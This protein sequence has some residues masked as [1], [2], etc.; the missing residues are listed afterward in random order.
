MTPTLTISIGRIAA[1]IGVPNKAENAA[2][3]PHMIMTCLSLSSKRNSF[4]KAFPILPPICNAA[5]SR[6][7]EP[8]NRCV[9]NVDTKIRGAIRSGNSS[10]EWMAEMTRFVPVSFSLCKKRYIATIP[11]PP[12]G[13]RKIS[14]VFCVRKTVTNDNAK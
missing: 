7:A 2:L 5:P 8:P 1:A 6:P 10:S 9:I 13:N 3:I 12:S 11:R 14:Q 4:P